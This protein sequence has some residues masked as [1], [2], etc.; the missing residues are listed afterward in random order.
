MYDERIETNENDWKSKCDEKRAAREFTMK[1][2]TN[3]C[4]ENYSLAYAKF[5]SICRHSIYKTIERCVKYYY[6]CRVHK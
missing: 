3:K 1:Q 5:R 6:L 2:I 4:L